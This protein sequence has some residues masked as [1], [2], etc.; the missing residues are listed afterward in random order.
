MNEKIAASIINTINYSH[1]FSNKTT[2]LRLIF[3]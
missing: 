2:I 1:F 3:Q